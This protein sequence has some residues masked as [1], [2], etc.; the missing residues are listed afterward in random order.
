[1]TDTIA[2]ANYVACDGVELAVL[3]PSPD[4]ARGRRQSEIKC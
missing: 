2:Y 1:M 4:I 3:V